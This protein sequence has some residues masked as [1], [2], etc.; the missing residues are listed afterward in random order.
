MDEKDSM[1]F[2]DWIKFIIEEN[3]G[4]W[5]ELY[6]S[7]EDKSNTLFIY[8]CL[9]RIEYIEE[10]LKDY[11]WDFHITDRFGSE[12]I[13]PLLIKRHFYGLKPEYWEITEDIILFFN[14]FEDKQNKKFIYIDDNGDDEEVIV[15]LDDE[16]K[17]KNSFLK[18]YLHAKKLVLVQF[19]DLFRYSE[20]TIREL[21]LEA[22][23]SK[24]ETDSY[25]YHHVLNNDSLS[26]TDKKSISSLIGKKIIAPLNSFKSKIFSENKEYEEFIIGVDKDGNNKYFTC[27]EKH[28]SNYYGAN[29]GNPHFLT[30]IYFEKKVLDKYYSQPEKY[31]VS[32]GYLSCKDM[33]DLRMDNSHNDYVMV[34]LGDLGHL[35][36]KEQ[37]HWKQF[38]ILTE[39]KISHTCFQ[40]SF[41]A[42]FCDPDSAD[43]F[44]KQKF[45]IFQEKWHEKYGW[46]L[47]LPLSPEDKHHYQ[48]LRIPTKESQQEFDSLIQSLTK[49]TVDSLNVK[50]LKKDL[51]KD[52][53]DAKL[54]DTV[55]GEFVLLTD[56][57]NQDNKIEI[58]RKYLAQ[59]HHVLFPDIS[60]FLKSLQG[61]RSSG[62]AHRKGD[63]YEKSKK[64][65]GLNNNFK[66]VFEKILVEC[67]KTLNTLSNQKNGLV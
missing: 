51:I 10:S 13:L 11:S 37:K 42:K 67:I 2:K 61:L 40:R 9:L 4:T 50:E 19:F 62:S 53:D 57:Q 49:L 31:S 24:E 59:K 41:M 55:K 15:I 7:I 38:N 33:W 48:A 14:L 5:I 28:L 52:T 65:F 12:N 16:V 30:Q 21:G 8:S 27:N 29:K 20:K 35:N 58:F 63:A 46:Y 25:I 23:D 56:V 60:D 18:E 26:I 43:L 39:G 6:K 44:F 32:D 45:K 22:T 64:K 1:Q 54:K 17:I 47:F 66:E 3:S 36:N 34:F